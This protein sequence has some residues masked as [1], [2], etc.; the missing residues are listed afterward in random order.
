MTA[1]TLLTLAGTR[2]RFPSVQSNIYFTLISKEFR[3]ILILLFDATFNK[4]SLQ[5]SGQQYYN[6]GNLTIE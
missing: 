5:C 6:S 4:V 1:E 3:I 2:I